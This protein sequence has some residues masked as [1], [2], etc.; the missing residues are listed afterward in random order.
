MA[1]TCTTPAVPTLQE[2]NDDVRITRWDFAPGANTGWHEHAMRYCVVMLTEG[3]L[4]IHDGD[5]GEA[6]AA[7]RRPEL[8]AGRP[9]SSTT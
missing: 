3:T 7:R 8:F 6:R 4:A 5:R 1:F 9:A 2:D